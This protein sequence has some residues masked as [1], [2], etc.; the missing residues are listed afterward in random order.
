MCITECIPRV[1]LILL[2][3]VLPFVAIV[4]PSNKSGS[5]SQSFSAEDPRLLV[6]Q[7]VYMFHVS[8]IEFSKGYLTFYKNMAIFCAFIQLCKN[9]KI[10]ACE[11]E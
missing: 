1:V 6:I 5:C 7:V 8:V 3:V 4:H 2:H 10:K 9:Q 11:S